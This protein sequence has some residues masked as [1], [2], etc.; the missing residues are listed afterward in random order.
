MIGHVISHYKILEKLGE[1]GMGV[2]YKAHDTKL[3]RD[4]ALKFLPSELTRDAEART[5]FILEAQT[6]SSLDHPNICTMYE[7]GTTEDNRSFIAMAFY[8]GET[9]KEKIAHGSLPVKQATEIAI[10][11]AQGLQKAHQR[12]IVHR[13]I[14]PANI[15][16]TVDGIVKILDF[17]LAKLKGSAKLTRSGSTVGTAA[18]M[19][20]EQAR[21]EEIDH[22]SDIF[23]FGTVFYELLTG[24]L[25]FRGEHE[26]ALVYSI[27]NE[28]PTPDGS[29]PQRIQRIIDRCLQK[30]KEKRY[31]HADEII[32]EIRKVQLGTGNVVATIPR[33]KRLRWIL[34][35]LLFII[36]LVVLYVVLV[37]TPQDAERK[38][39]AVLPFTDLS[40]EK[41][42]EYFCDG[43]SE[44]IINALTKIPSLYVASRTSAFQFKGKDTD[45]R[46][47]GERLD[48]TTVLEGSVRKSGTNL[49]ITAQLI[50]TSDGYHLW[51][52]TYDRTLDDVFSIQESISR[53][54]VNALKLKLTLGENERIVKQYTDDLEA[55]T[56]Y[57]QGRY[58]WNMRSEDAMRKSIVYFNQALEHDPQ[59]ALAYSGIADAYTVL[60][61]WGFISTGEGYPKGYSAAKRALDFD[62]SL[63]EAITTTAYI[64]YTYERDYPTAEVLFKKAIGLN[65]NYATAHQW[66]S[67]FL[68]ALG[69][70]DEALV[71]IKKASTL[72]PTSLIISTHEGAIYYISRQYNKAIMHLKNVFNAD[73][74]FYPA[75][76]YSLLSYYELGNFKDMVITNR[77]MAILEGA[78]AQDLANYDSAYSRD[79]VKGIY[80]WQINRYKE[81]SKSRY[82]STDRVAIFYTIL[83]QKDSAFYWLS[84]ALEKRAPLLYTLYVWPVWDKLRD[85]P[86]YDVLLRRLK[87]K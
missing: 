77:K 28:A 75:Y 73:S 39:I 82:I 33:F 61:D 45:I 13:D 15:F 14:K 54:I 70:R 30:D 53:F 86:R 1:G 85:D 3:N 4:V 47:I 74:N 11:I 62:S 84:E 87:F 35:G 76:V 37:R 57:L 60:A 9:L 66:Y 31:Q 32:D 44:E 51:S 83:G 67:E 69:R 19:S 16:L 56:L 17:G 43:M 24:K 26:A 63:A 21:G 20:P 29:I 58:Y 81:M 79:G 23:S 18:Y 8:E 48:V 6:A 40:P 78:D 36:A 27:V 10:Q 49:R 22:R 34:A 68:G 55:Y 80:H 71:E 64:K 46:T 38:S 52:E 7:I 72:D 2:V 42:Q 65:P 25:P 5:R 50:K 41:D 59:Y 12:G